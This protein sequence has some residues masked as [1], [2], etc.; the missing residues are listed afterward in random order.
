[1]WSGDLGLTNLADV[2]SLAPAGGGLV[3]AL[4]GRGDHIL[5]QGAPPVTPRLVLIDPAKRRVVADA[6]L[7][8]EYGPVSWHG[9]FSLR[10]GPGSA[11]YGATAY[12]VF[13]IKPGTCE[14]ERVWQ[15]AVPRKQ[16]GTVWLTNDPNAIDVVGPIVGREFYF[17]TGWRLRALTLP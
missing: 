11:V 4:I 7:P 15:S 17:G 3:Y 2:C 6:W 8:E 13:R 5:S 14:V 10:V 16:D 1:M 9:L 12:C